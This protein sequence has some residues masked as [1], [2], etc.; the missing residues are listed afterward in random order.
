MSTTAPTSAAPG[1]AAPVPARAPR[2]GRGWALTGVLAGVGGITSIQA[3]TAVD[4]A[5]REDLAGDAAGITEALAGQ[6]TPLLVFHTATTLTTVLLLVV[7]AGLHRRLA[8]ALPTGSLLPG[9]AAAGLGLTAV[10]GL[11]GSALDTEFVFGLQDTSRLVPET[12]ALYGHW[13]GTVP[14]LWLGSGV[15]ALAV[16]AAALRSA[17]L[18]RWIG[19]VSLVLGVLTTLLGV[20]PL[21][22]MAGMTGPVWLLVAMLGFWLGD[23]R[24]RVGA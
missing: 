18:P 4:A 13:V 14:W 17:A 3:S 15:A 19:W 22:Y 21:Q 5:Y 20:S 10:A 23:R 11:M 7:A 8:A 12:A 24:G 6:T 1:T 16:A 2:T 9:I